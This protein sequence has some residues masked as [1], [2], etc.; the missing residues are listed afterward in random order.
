MIRPRIN[1]WKGPT[2]DLTFC[3]YFLTSFRKDCDPHLTKGGGVGHWQAS[4]SEIVQKHF[5]PSDMLLQAKSGGVVVGW[6]PF[7]SVIILHLYTF[8]NT[9][10]KPCSY[11]IMVFFFFHRHFP[12]LSSHWK[13]RA[14]FIL[15]WSILLLAVWCLYRTKK[16]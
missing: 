9:I 14:H 16:E 15:N 10:A 7:C 12:R 8:Y 3:I 4:Y 1:I 2:R 13:V 5:H 11:R 6:L